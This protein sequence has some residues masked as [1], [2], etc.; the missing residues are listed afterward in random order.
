M[1]SLTK[2]LAE[3][4]RALGYFEKRALE[5]KEKVAGL[6]AMLQIC[7]IGGLEMHQRYLQIPS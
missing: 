7:R 3:K 1:K 5:A 2:S 4:Q 6:E